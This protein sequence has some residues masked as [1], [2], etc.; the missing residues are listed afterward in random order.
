MIDK[1]TLVYTYYEAPEMLRQQV[2]YW[3]EYPKEVAERIQI[4]IIDDGSPN[5]PAFQA[6]SLILLKLLSK[7]DIK[8]YMIKEDIN[9][10]TFGA[11][12]LAFTLAKDGWIWNLDIDHVVPAESLINLFKEELKL[13]THY[14]PNRRIMTTMEESES[15]WRH[16]DSFIITREMFWEL[17]G[18]DESYTGYYYH[19]PSYMFRQATKKK[20]PQYEL[21][22][23]WSL[24]FGP[25]LIADASPLLHEKKIRLQKYINNNYCPTDP[26]RFEWDE[27]KLIN[28]LV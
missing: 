28:D 20:Y 11:R 12:N 9:Q 15:I 18:Y 25:D 1:I 23:I 22:N 21:D 7:I 27:V 19:G 17:G 5:N 8:L 16:S 14:L 13:N 4:I 24:L 10:N 2:R 3:N 6:M 26:L